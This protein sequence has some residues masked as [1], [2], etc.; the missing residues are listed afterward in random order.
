MGVTSI[1]IPLS[2]SSM[3][4]GVVLVGAVLLL[5]A[6]GYEKV[7]NEI[8]ENIP[9]MTRDKYG[10]LLYNGEEVV[11]INGIGTGPEEVVDM[12][13]VE[14]SSPVE[15]MDEVVGLAE[16]ESLRKVYD[17]RPVISMQEIA[18]MK[19]LA[20]MQE[21][22]GM[23]EVDAQEVVGMDE[24][25]K[26]EEVTKIQ[27]VRVQEVPEDVFEEF[28]DWRFT[29]EQPMPV[30]ARVE[31]ISS[32]L[33]LKRKELVVRQEELRSMLRVIKKLELTYVAEIEEM[34]EVARMEEIA[35]MQEVKAE[36]VKATE[37]KNV[38]EITKMMEL[39]P[40]EAAKL[41]ALLANQYKVVAKSHY[42]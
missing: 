26:M 18:R 29:E 37:L 14:S 5:G 1:P 12:E 7:D 31:Q 28:N 34:G 21:V 23:Q 33:E 19:E 32:L 16:V 30:S 38:Q 36:E 9:G 8:I 40:K 3:I 39:T 10:N 13:E 22:L 41:K 35:R 2:R 15:K 11:S 6:H 42:Y 4:V 20:N 25:L 27:P 24:V 17:K